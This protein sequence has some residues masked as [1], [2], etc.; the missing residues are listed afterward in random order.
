[1]IR[2]GEEYLRRLLKSPHAGEHWIND[3]IRGWKTNKPP[4]FPPTQLRLM[5]RPLSNPVR[6]TDEDGPEEYQEDGYNTDDRLLLVRTD[7]L[8]AKKVKQLSR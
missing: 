6:R 8:G 1:M 5:T 7:T 4:G 3:F 2:L